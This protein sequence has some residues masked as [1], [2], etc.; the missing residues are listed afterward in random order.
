LPGNDR[1]GR[2]GKELW[3]VATVHSREGTRFFGSDAR[4]EPISK[5]YWE[6][7]KT[8]WE[9]KKGK[10]DEKE[11]SIYC[12]R[13]HRAPL[14]FQKKTNSKPRERKITE[15]KIPRTPATKVGKVFASTEG[16][17]SIFPA[18]RVSRREFTGEG[19]GGGN[20]MRKKKGGQKE[21]CAE[22]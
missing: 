15:Q 17:R 3:G 12:R 21:H 20:C 6:E 7:K 5:N 13:S 19:G 2:E 11:R 8:V 18:H 22:R 14:R 10:I 16:R 1:F 4:R 9:G